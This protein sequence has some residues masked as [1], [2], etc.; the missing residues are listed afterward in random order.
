[1]FEKL[2]AVGHRPPVLVNVDIVGGI[3][4][5]A[6]GLGFLSQHIEGVISTHRH[7]IELAK[8]KGLFTVQ[9]LFAINSGAVEQGVRLIRRAKPHCVEIL[10]ALA[11]PKSLRGPSSPVAFSRPRRRL[12]DPRRW[13]HRGF[14]EYTRTLALSTGRALRKA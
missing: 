5:D 4:A 6:S 9:R 3:S 13:R 1:V 12:R 11:Y 8:E 14:N 10:P 7:V 2:R